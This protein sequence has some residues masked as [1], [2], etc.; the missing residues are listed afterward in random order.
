M[1][2]GRRTKVI[3]FLVIPVVLVLGFGG[4]V[5]WD[6]NGGWPGARAP[7]VT[8][9]NPT[10]PAL[11]ARKADAQ[12][13]VAAD[14]TV[15][16]GMTPAERFDSDECVKGQNNVKHVDGYVWQCSITGLQLYGFGGGFRK[17]MASLQS[18]LEAQGWTP[19]VEDILTIVDEPVYHEADVRNYPSIFYQRNGTRLELGFAPKGWHTEFTSFSGWPQADAAAAG[20]AKRRNVLGVRYFRVYFEN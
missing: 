16:E 11:V 20:L 19:E 6:L 1:R 18:R 9:P 15:I 5:W 7:F 17:G 14:L 2:F 3:V 13:T 10:D 12:K 8:A 4:K